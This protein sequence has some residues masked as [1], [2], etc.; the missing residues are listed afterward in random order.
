VVVPSP[1]ADTNAATTEDEL[2]ELRRRMRALKL[3]ADA[4]SRMAP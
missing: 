2:E 4:Y 1:P 3:R